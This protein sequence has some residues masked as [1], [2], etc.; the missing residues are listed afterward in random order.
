MENKR[1]STSTMPDRAQV[2]DPI[3]EPHPEQHGTPQAAGSG[4]TTV[5]PSDDSD[6]TLHGRYGFWIQ[7]LKNN[8]I[9][10]HRGVYLSTF[11]RGRGQHIT[12]LD[13]GQARRLGERL[14]ALADEIETEVGASMLPHRSRGSI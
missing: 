4:R 12:A 5:E 8:P 14:I 2:A 11:Q 7:T 9:G 6:N 10:I 13:T 1:M 3:T